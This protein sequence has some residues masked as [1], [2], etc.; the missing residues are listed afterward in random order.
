[1]ERQT[2][3]R[4]KGI[5]STRAKLAPLRER[6]AATA[7]LTLNAGDLVE[8][9]PVSTV[10]EGVPDYEIAMQGLAAPEKLSTVRLAKKISLP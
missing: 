6:A 7:S 9:T 4:R 1:M 5:I 8:G 2:S 10:F 3:K